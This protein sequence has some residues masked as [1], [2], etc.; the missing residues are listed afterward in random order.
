MA[1]NVL[2]STFRIKKKKKKKD[3]THIYLD[4]VLMSI[5]N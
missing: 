1:A 5:K 2:C 3:N 4:R